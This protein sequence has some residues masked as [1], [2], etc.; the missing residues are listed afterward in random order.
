MEQGSFDLDQGG[1]VGDLLA[2]HVADVEGVDHPIAEGLDLG[3][4]DVEVQVGQRAGD[5]V[6]HADRVH[7]VHLHDG[8]VARR[9]GCRRPRAAARA[10]ACAWRELRT[11]GRVGQPGLEGQSALEHLLE[12]GDDL[13]PGD[14]G[15]EARLDAEHLEGDPVEAGDGRVEHRQAVQR[16]HAGDAREQA[17]PVGRDDGE[18]VAVAAEP[19][20]TRS[21]ELEVLGVREVVAHILDGAAAQ[22]VGGAGHQVADEV[23]LPRAPRRR[24]GGLAVRLGEGGEQPEGAQSPTAS[25]TP[26]MVAGSSRS[27]RVATSGRSRW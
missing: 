18:P 6:Q 1:G 3:R 10:P 17:G 21:H 15:P 11:H 12:V 4:H 8:G 25:A 14:G 16:Q 26:S 13:V 9:R 7:R 2:G 19:L 24:S 23:R 20:A 22:H 27:R 5:A